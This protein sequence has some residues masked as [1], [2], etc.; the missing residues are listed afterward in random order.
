[1]EQFCGDNNDNFHTYVLSVSDEAFLLLV[2]ISSYGP[3]WYS[4]NE[5]ERHKVSKRNDHE[6]GEV[7][8]D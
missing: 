3:T 5:L 7:A 8:N 4:E 2:L 1:M 6:N